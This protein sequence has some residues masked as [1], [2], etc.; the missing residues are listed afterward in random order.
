MV[1]LSV[2]QGPLIYVIK[3]DTEAVGPRVGREGPEIEHL[4]KK[5]VL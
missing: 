3:L 2:V 4:T 5:N 1:D